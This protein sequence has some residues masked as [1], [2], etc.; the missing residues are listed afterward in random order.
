MKK[1]EIDPN[2]QEENVGHQYVKK[3]LFNLIQDCDVTFMEEESLFDS[4]KGPIFKVEKTQNIYLEFPQIINNTHLIPDITIF[5]DDKKIKT[6]IEV[7]DTGFPNYKK[8][9]AYS[10]LNANIFFLFTD[11]LKIN[12]FN[13][14]KSTKWTYMKEKYGKNIFLYTFRSDPLDHFIGTFFFS[15]NMDKNKKII[16]MSD[17]LMFN[18]EELC[19]KDFCYGYLTSHPNQ[20]FLFIDKQGYYSPIKFH[21]KYKFIAE[22]DRFNKNYPKKT[23][24]WLNLIFNMFKDLNVKE[25]TVYFSRYNGPYLSKT[26]KY[27]SLRDIQQKLNP[28]PNIK[29]NE[30]NFFKPITW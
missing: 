2:L 1:Y 18:F 15:K 27:V 22:K 17:F 11:R 21:Q 19:E 29:S 9:K 3:S 4:S 10:D 24:K 16:E 7:V 20:G 23:S 26:I 13:L 14:D 6:I 28:S 5:D 12:S 25:K 8:L 30:S